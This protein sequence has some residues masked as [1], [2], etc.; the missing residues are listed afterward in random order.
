MPAEGGFDVQ[1]PV[2]LTGDKQLR[3][4]GDAIAAT[5][6][7]AAAAAGRACGGDLHKC[8]HGKNSPGPCPADHRHD[9]VV[10]S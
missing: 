3:G 4:D 10:L 8:G 6:A 5:G 2:L 7:K 1:V 9:P